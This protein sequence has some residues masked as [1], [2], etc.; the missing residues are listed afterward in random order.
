[1]D[2]AAILGG[3]MGRSIRTMS[4]IPF[5]IQSGT[6][7]ASSFERPFYG[8]LGG[9]RDCRQEY[10]SLYSRRGKL[11][12]GGCRDDRTEGRRRS[13]R[14]APLRDDRHAGRRLSVY[15]AHRRRRFGSVPSR[16]RRDKEFVVGGRF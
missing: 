16:Y 5:L 2:A 15:R 12:I 11:R 1:M 4:T 3:G 13:L 10:L 14:R 9:T 8:A 6:D 7:R